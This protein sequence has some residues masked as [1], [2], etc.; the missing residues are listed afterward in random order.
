MWDGPG[1]V[2][3]EGNQ[4]QAADNVFDRDRYDIHDRL[5]FW[6]IIADRVACFPS[7]WS[8]A[9]ILAVACATARDAL[10]KRILCLN[11]SYVLSAHSFSFRHLDVLS[12]STCAL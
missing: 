1:P 9:T 2:H 6:L 5:G 7:K 3:T 12:A 10:Q 11:F 8:A 4:Y